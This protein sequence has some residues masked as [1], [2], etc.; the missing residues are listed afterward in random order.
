[1]ALNPQQRAAVEHGEGPLL[2]V[3]GAG[4]GKTRVIVERVGYLLKANP[5][6]R[7]EQILALTFTEKAAA[8][9][10]QRAAERFGAE[11]SGC[12]FAT[13]HSFCYELLAESGPVR[14]LD[15]IDQWIFLRRHLDELDLEHYF[16]V[17]EPGRFLSDLVNFCSRCHDNLVTPAE[18][19][20]YIEKLANQRGANSRRAG[21]DGN[22]ELSRQREVARVFALLEKL[23]EEQGLVSFGA[24]ISRAVRLLDE[25]PALRARLQE[26]YRYILVDEFQD[27]NTAQFELLTRL[28]GER[29]NLT[30]VGDDD[31][32]IYRFRGAS[33]ASFQQ[34]GER[35][36]EHV[37]VVLD[38]NYRSTKHI[39]AIAGAAIAGNSQDRYLPEKRLVT[40][41]EAGPAVEL[42]EFPDEVAQ[43]EHT[44]EWIAECVRRGEAKAYSEFAVLYR[45]H[46]HRNRLVEALRSRGVPFEIRRLAIQDMPLVRDLVAWLRILGNSRDSVSLVRVLA[47]P[48]WE[49]P[50]QAL[51]HYCREAA[52]QTQSLWDTVA[53]PAGA[54]EWPERGRFLAFRNRFAALANS[55]PISAWFPLLTAEMGFPRCPEDQAAFTTFNA[56]LSRWEKEKSATGLLQE[57]LEYF[58]Y[59]EE[60]GGTIAL[61]EEREARWGGP[62][63]WG[64]QAALW[65]SP[66]EEDRLGKVQLMTVH[67]A[68][69]LE[70]D[71]VIVW[72]LVRRAFPTTHRRPLI[73]LPPE[74]WKGPLPRGDFHTE[75]ERRLF[76]VALTRARRSLI[77]A[78]ISNQRQRPSPFVDQLQEIPSP[79]LLRKR[80]VYCPPPEREK[81]KTDS[82]LLDAGARLAEW[83]LK[84]I[85]PPPGDLTLSI[86]Q[87]ETYQQCPLKYHLDQHWRIPVPPSPPMLFGTV[88]HAALKE[89]VAEAVQR[90]GSVA[91]AVIREILDR[92]WPQA[93]FPDAVQERRYRQ[94]ALEQLAGVAQQWGTKGIVL[95][96]QEKSF[97]LRSG[98][99]R[100]VGR[101]DQIHRVAG[102]GVELVEYKTGRP[103]TQHD[104]DED[105]QITLYA[106]ACRQVLGLEP[107]AL[108]LY[109]LA[110]QEPLRTQR[111]AQEY[112]ELEQAIGDAAQRILAGQFPA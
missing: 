56:F 71:R 76:Y 80:P 90:R 12:R 85:V 70:F 24:M 8:E 57:F 112:R 65:E 111:S 97:E 28:A 64:A 30:V 35:Y 107:S 40:D 42:W 101:I 78:T 6:L 68:K 31:Q 44:A 19:A 14:A 63:T 58:Q 4:T 108:I 99:C 2:I 38:R 95:L 49:M 48:R 103:Q 62:A 104:A 3:A 67:G 39:L 52:R 109:N 36:P 5:G 53:Q 27:T 22:A 33:F 82:R 110:G 60:A 72:H 105:Q 75:E 88:V 50:P 86:S 54:E 55:S 23:Q 79:Q 26:R 92:H 83:F 100:L 93:G 102:G 66:R 81:K 34:F 43:A 47:D 74:L 17:S 91:E 20:G 21:G 16:K 59:F 98:G 94:Q 87:L 77:L 15:P 9:M 37:R 69:G 89:V 32:A 73:E 25:D 41:N 29:K 84:P 61:G 10:R 45:A 106:E 46:S 18:Y 11:A 7:P 1:V 51:L 13:F 96:Y